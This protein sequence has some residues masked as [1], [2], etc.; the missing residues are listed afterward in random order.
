MEYLKQVTCI[1]FMYNITSREILHWVFKFNGI[2]EVNTK[3]KFQFGYPRYFSLPIEYP[4]RFTVR[5]YMN[6]LAV[7]RELST[8]ILHVALFKEFPVFV[9]GTK[10][11]FR[12][13]PLHF[14]V[15]AE[16]YEVMCIKECII[17]QCCCI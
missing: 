16:L 2:R 7:S 13:F 12:N 1:F 17:L 4:F 9:F 11:K 15:R 5:R 8:P 14:A 3:P 10:R 6:I